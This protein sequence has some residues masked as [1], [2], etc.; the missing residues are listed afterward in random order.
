MHLLFGVFC[1]FSVFSCLFIFSVGCF[2]LCVNM[3]MFFLLL[4]VVFEDY[5]ERMY[6]C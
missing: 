5:V 2:V 1:L 4:V 6:V 3:L